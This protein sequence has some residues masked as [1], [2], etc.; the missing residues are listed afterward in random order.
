M[1]YKLVVC[2]RTD[3]GM[4]KGKLAAQVGHASVKAAN[5]AR[6]KD[7]RAYDAWLRSGQ[8]KIVVKVKSIDQLEE[9]ERKARD[10]KL[11]THRI[12]DAGHTQLDPGT[13]TVLAVG[14]A[15]AGRI[16]AVTGHL[17]LY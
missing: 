16:D 10:A 12:S 13:T 4:G 6:T 8:P 14:P 5:A 9:V 2:A 17:K 11:P 15:D 7:K 1:G 3:I